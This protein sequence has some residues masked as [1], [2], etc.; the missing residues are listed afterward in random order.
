MAFH[1]DKG[2]LQSVSGGAVDV[3]RLATGQQRLTDE[4]RERT[5]TRAIAELY[6]R[7]VPSNI[8]VNVDGKGVSQ[9]QAK[10]LTILLHETQNMRAR[11]CVWM[12]KACIRTAK[13]SSCLDEAIAAMEDELQRPASRPEPTDDKRSSE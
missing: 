9:K 1:G 12:L 3:S 2:R 4:E 8:R 13:K 6:N 7:V 5:E 11:A 10:R